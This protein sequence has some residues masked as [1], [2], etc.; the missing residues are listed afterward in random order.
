MSSMPPGPAGTSG[1]ANPS[2]PV[3][4][5][6]LGTVDLVEVEAAAKRAA[7]NLGVGVEVAKVAAL[8]PGH[9]EAARSQS[10]ALKVI[11][12]VPATF[13]APPKPAPGTT[14]DPTATRAA[15]L[16]PMESWGSRVHGAPAPTAPREAPK[17]PMA[18]VRVGVTDTDLFAGHKDFVFVHAEPDRRRA[19]VS[20]RRMKEAFWKRKSD[21]SR[22]QTRLV[23][24]IVGAVALAAGAAPCENPT[25]PASSARGPL[26]IDQKGDRLCPNCDRK[27]RG[28]S[29]RM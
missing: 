17:T 2:T 13:V 27:V 20:L 3:T 1:G 29:L 10:D 12:A 4:V 6:P 16:S 5:H 24:E 11:G 15:A 7:K 26:D 18:H 9:F 21:P 14:A 23:R 8:P 22:Q 25:C 19:I 28:G